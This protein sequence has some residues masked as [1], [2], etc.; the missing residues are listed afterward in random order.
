MCYS[1]LDIVIG[2]PDMASSLSN[3]VQSLCKPVDANKDGQD[4]KDANGNLIYP[5]RCAKT[6]NFPRFALSDGKRLFVA[7]GGNDRVLIFNTIPTANGAAA[8]VILGQPDEFVSTVSSSTD[9]FHPLLR[10]SAADITATPTSLAWDGT[11]LYVADPSNRRVMVFTE[12][13]P[14]I[15]INGIRNAASRE[16]FALGSISIRLDRKSTRLNSSH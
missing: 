6:M 4:D 9:L 3:N 7:D 8:D 16:V 11:N 13:E 15:P 14:L 2:Q 12:G 10:Q 1:D 5:F